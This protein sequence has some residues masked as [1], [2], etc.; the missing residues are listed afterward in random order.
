[1][2]DYYEGS[3]ES[4][5]T[6]I[7][8]L[9]T[10]SANV[11]TCPTCPTCRKPIKNIRRYGRIIKK[12]ILSMQNRN[13]LT[14]YGD[15]LNKIIEQIILFEDE[16]NSKRDKLQKSL[17]KLSKIDDSMP[18]EI[19]FKKLNIKNDELPGITPH[20]YF[21]NV[22]KYHGFE[23]ISKKVWLDH[24]GKLLKCYQELTFI[25]CATNTSPHKK[26][27]EASFSNL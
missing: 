25:L 27:F 24:V 8:I 11:K 12:Y 17:R 13:F 10:P 22:K 5:W 15:Q 9:S 26:A 19:E 6:S 2:K 20:Q 14:T 7:K 23:K 1:M 4:G 16:I 21:N 3:I 18:L